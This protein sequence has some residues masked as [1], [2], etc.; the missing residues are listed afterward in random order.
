M[1]CD[2]R[3]ADNDEVEPVPGVPEVGELGQRKA[4]PHNFCGRLKG[5]DGSE[6]DPGNVFNSCK[7]PANCTLIYLA[8]KASV[9]REGSF[10]FKEPSSRG[11]IF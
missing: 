7:K 9:L 2:L 3:K 6:D 8:K 1:V 10:N 4:A 5:V 11:P